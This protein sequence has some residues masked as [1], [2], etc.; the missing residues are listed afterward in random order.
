MKTNRVLR[1]I[2]GV[3][4]VLGTI[5]PM[6]VAA[7]EKKGGA[8][9]LMEEMEEVEKELEKRLKSLD[10]EIEI[11]KLETGMKMDLGPCHAMGL[12]GEGA[13]K[14]RHLSVGWRTAGFWGGMCGIVPGWVMYGLAGGTDP[15]APEYLVPEDP[16]LGK[17]FREGYAAQARRMNARA[18][19][20][21]CGFATFL[22][23]TGFVS[24]VIWG[25]DK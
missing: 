21:G 14:D 9:K 24:L 15:E 12:E 16:E 13:A 8:A 11:H 10:K 4:L 25:K 6:G 22:L 18:A 20:Q 5:A 7:E 23:V 3:V 2:M 1:A 19:M 17:C